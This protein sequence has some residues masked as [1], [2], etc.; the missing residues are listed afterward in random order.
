M[1]VTRNGT[2]SGTYFSTLPLS[3]EISFQNTSSTGPSAGPP[4]VLDVDLRGSE[5]PWKYHG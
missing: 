4:I 5:I 1:T 2:S 3:V